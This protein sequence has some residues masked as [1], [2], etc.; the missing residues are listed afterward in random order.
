MGESPWRV[1]DISPYAA[2]AIALQSG[3]YVR[4]Y[5]PVPVAAPARQVLSPGVNVIVHNDVRPHPG[6]GHSQVTRIQ[7]PAQPRQRAGTL[8]EMW[9]IP[10]PEGRFA[11]FEFNRDNSFIAIEMLAGGNHHVH[12]GEYV[13]PRPYIIE[14]IDLGTLRI[15][16]RS[17][18]NVDLAFATVCAPEAL[19]PIAAVR[20]APMPRTPETDMIARTWRIVR[21]NVP[22]SVGS[23]VLFSINGTYLWADPGGHSFV[24]RWRWHNQAGGEFDYSHDDWWSYG[25]ARVSG[26][27]R[28]FARIDDPG[29][30]TYVPGFSTAAGDG[31]F[32]LEPVTD[33]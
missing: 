15:L 32:E 10:G 1:I 20:E 18:D 24:S 25:R 13:M 3:G 4:V 11:S 19:I 28:S 22:G 6:G 16:A 14:M 21:S 30:L 29:F 8:S 26:L 12:F 17:G 27:T 31:F 9:V 23:T 2:R 7:I 33:F 5:Y